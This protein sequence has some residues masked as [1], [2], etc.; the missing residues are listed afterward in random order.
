MASVIDYIDCPHCKAK[1]AFIDMDRW[2]EHIFCNMCGYSKQTFVTN[3][4]EAGKEGWIP[5]VETMVENN[6]YGAYYVEYNGGVADAGTLHE[7]NSEEFLMK[8]IEIH[9]D[10]IVRASIRKY[11]NGEHTITYIIGDEEKN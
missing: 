4:D 2:S 8:E 7:E 10:D 1:D 3:L 5:E 9:K 6:P 11:I